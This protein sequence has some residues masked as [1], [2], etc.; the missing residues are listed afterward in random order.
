MNVTC[1]DCLAT[2]VTTA[3]P[4]D[5]EIHPRAPRCATH[6]R[7]RLK[8]TRTARKD[9]AACRTYGL[10]PG[11]RELLLRSQRGLCRVC[12]PF[13]GKRARTV[14][15]NHRTG[16]VRGMLCQECNK[17]IG[18]FRDNPLVFACFAEYLRNPPAREVL[19]PRDWTPYADD[20]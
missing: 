6:R 8:A 2:G 12:G 7:E 1:V 9:G 10:L 18:Y 19:P 17:I 4:T 15:H 11:E 14:D 5:A 20:R 16:E 3:R 13:L